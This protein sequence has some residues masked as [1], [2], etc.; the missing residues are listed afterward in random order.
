VTRGT[1]IC[2]S[3]IALLAMLA[4]ARSPSPPLLLVPLRPIWTLA[5]NNRLTLPP[6]ID[7]SHALFAI[8]EN[9]LV[10][11]DLLPGTQTWLVDA[12]PLFQPVID[13]AFV[14]LAETSALVALH[15]N[16]GSVAWRTAIEGSLGKKPT[17]AN[18]WIVGVTTGGTVLAFR[19]SDG[20]LVWRRAIGAQAHAS[21]LITED[22]V[23]V[24]A[25]DGRVIALHREDGEPIWERRIGGPPNDP[26]V[27]GDRLYVGSTDNFFYCLLTKDGQIDWRW[28]TGADV[29]GTPA[30]D[31]R[32]VYF[33][34]LDNVV[35]AMNRVSGGQDWM[36]ALPLRPTSGPLLIAD[37]LVISGQSSTIRTLAAKDGAPAPDISAGE[38]VV[39]PPWAGVQPVTGLPML[40]V[41]T[42]NLVRGDTAALSVRSIDPIPTPIAPLSNP[43][44]LAPTLPTRP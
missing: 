19:T 26:A 6:A 40:L 15:M 4:L 25:A 41:V 3:A 8:E 16:D 36:R 17:A 2:C 23:Y 12:R 30:G 39:A 34:S 31:A 42:R 37:T 44:M 32:R 22:R 7:A 14:V 5:L 29:I 33:V 21:P 20:S 24:P 11:Y 38:E 27:F 35:R 1:T 13:G 10:A 28:R 18:G 43:I 9:R